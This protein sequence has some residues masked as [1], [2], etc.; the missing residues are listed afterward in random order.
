MIHCFIPCIDIDASK[1]TIEKLSVDSN[2]SKITLLSNCDI[3]PSWQPYEKC[4]CL[5][6]KDMFSSKT[7]KDIAQH[8]KDE[9]AL[10]ITKVTPISF[11]TNALH[12]FLQ[13]AIDTQSPFVYSDYFKE[14]IRESKVV[15][16]HPVI[17]YFEGS[18]R[19]DFD[20][21]SVW[22]IKADYLK[23]YASEHSTHDFVHAGH[24]ALRLFLSR[25][26][27][28]FHINEFLYTEQ[29]NDLRN[30]GE[31]QFDYVNPRN[32]DVQIEMENIA[33]S[34]LKSIDALVNTT[35]YK[36]VDFEEVKFDY[37]ASVIIPVFN[38]EKTIC[39]AVKSA[40]NQKTDFCFNVIVVDNHSTD[41]TTQL[42]Q[43]INDNRLIHIIPERV[44]LGIGGCWNVAINDNRC[45]R[46]AVQL[47]SDD[48][49]SSELTLQRVVDEFY[50]QKSAMII[51]S[52]RMCDFSLNT[53]P[54]GIID[55]REWTDE[56]GA[57]NALRINGLGAPRAF[58]TPVIRKIQFPNTSY[59]EDY[60]VGLRISREYKIGRIYD[61][62]YLCRRWGGNSDAAL[63][64]EKIN[65]N[66]LYKDRLR[67]LEL[68]A[69]RNQNLSIKKKTLEITTFFDNQLL[70]WSDARNRYKDLENVKVRE[71]VVN[72]FTVS[73]QYN[74]ARI[75]ST[76]SDVSKEKI[77]KRPCFLCKVN[78]PREQ[79]QL[80]I[81]DDLT[82]L[83][84]PYPIMH[85]HFTLP[86][87]CHKPQ[88]IIN[89]YGCIFDMLTLYGNGKLTVFYNGAMSGASAPD[90]LHLQAFS[91]EQLP[92]QKQW[93]SLKKSLDSWI[94]SNEMVEDEGVFSIKDYPTT[95]ILIQS[96]T[97][98]SFYRLFKGVFNALKHCG[99]NTPA[100]ED[101]LTEPQ[102]NI[103]SWLSEEIYY[104]VIF[105]RKQHRPSSYF[106]Q[107]DDKRL[108]SPGALDMSGLIITPRKE[109]FEQMTVDD[110]LK[111][112]N[113]VSY[114]VEELEQVRRYFTE[115]YNA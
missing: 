52:Y 29:E 1:T 97:K 18:I 75:I 22:F 9:Y 27:T 89:H 59:G 43:N 37:E 48:L 60:A 109:D 79:F 95:A 54:P 106:S 91:N 107:S 20:F 17:D 61:E 4:D 10:L 78:R 35:L 100:T 41:E 82:L 36:V 33:T 81:T 94:V 13:V 72:D 77:A 96:K 50:K 49:Y 46:F 70:T 6:V 87:N 40:L 111:I 99:Y 103:V 38:R 8:C 11:S 28:L 84:N 3:P 68:Q 16:G 51:G 53:L 2:V 86:S 7:I 101:G 47:D 102:M 39:D 15:V 115:H 34:H 56:N 67:T 12:R 88:L 76:G 83:V 26:G 30:S 104:S 21:G 24:Y 5:V 74:P 98:E 45:G 108:V 105:P 19:D 80:D 14:E 55:H 73:L 62:L 64:V 114:S 66:N 71:I 23:K 25:Q 42:L 65:R 110:I 69:R 112:Y 44:D 93:N 85:R 63:S 32:R 57:N 58:Y 31:K 113:E 92:I 90:H